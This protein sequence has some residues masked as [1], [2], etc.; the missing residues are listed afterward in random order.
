MTAPA[1]EPRLL[2]LGP[3]RWLGADGAAVDYRAERR[4]QLL[5]WLA[6]HAGRWLER[7]RIAAWLWPDHELGEARRNLRKVL[8]RAREVPGTHALQATETAL[9]WPIATDAQAIETASADE[10]HR[11]WRG[12]PLGGLDDPA[13]STWTDWL[14]QARTELT[15]R[16]QQAA[17]G[18]LRHAG[19]GAAEALARRL[20][21]LDPLDESAAQALVRALLASGQAAA[22]RQTVRAFAGR[23]AEELGVEPSQALTSLVAAGAPAVAAADAQAF[24]GRRLELRSL[25]QQLRASASALLTISGPGGVGKSRLARQLLV[26]VGAAYAGGARLVDLQ[27]VPDGG[28]ALSALALVLQVP[29]GA[30]G[31]RLDQVL[32]ALPQAPSLLVLD[33]TEH[34]HELARLVQQLRDAAPVLALVVTTR[35]RLHLPDEQV[36][37]LAGLEVPDDSSQDAEAAAA[38]DAVRLFEQRARAARPGF[39]LASC[40][41]AVIRIVE[42]VAGLPLA[43]ELAAGWVRLLPPEEIARDLHD[44]IEL[45]QRDPG[46]TSLPFGAESMRVALDRSWDLAAPA[47]RQALA[48]LSVFRGGF[49][50]AAARAVA[51]VALP[52]LASLVDKSLLGVDNDGR[53]AAHP[54][55]AAYARERLAVQAGRAAEVARRHR[56]HFAARLA[57]I[58]RQVHTPGQLQALREFDAESENLRVA[59]HAAIEASATDALQAM[60]LPLAIC[61]ELRGRWVEGVAW[62]QQAVDH[63]AHAVSRLPPAL[64]CAL[65]TLQ[66]RCG[67]TDVAEASARRGHAGARGMRDRA[68]LGASLSILGLVRWQRGDPRAAQR[69]FEAAL[70]HARRSGDLLGIATYAN[71]VCMAL[72]P[73]AAWDEATERCQEALAAARSLGSPK[74]IATALNHLGGIAF[75]QRRLDEAERAWDEGLALMRQMELAPLEVTFHANLGFVHFERRQLDLAERHFNE[76]A[77][78]DPARVE[79]L[80]RVGAF[81]GLGRIA[82]QR[83]DAAAVAHCV[84]RA[85]EISRQAGASTRLLEA[86]IVYGE[87]RQLAG[88]PVEAAACWLAAI[89]TGRLHAAQVVVVQ[90]MLD[91]L[92]LDDA[93]RAEARAQAQ[94]RPADLAVTHIL[95][96]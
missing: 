84:R 23:V 58:A 17:H 31:D 2:L 78:R 36:L 13:D 83:R 39:E 45:L 34:L 7:D 76:I 24:V 87:G 14:R 4:Y 42:A 55:V 43:I 92:G 21:A 90:Q 10:L 73:R 37:V 51:E 29:V 48:A 57:D 54:L 72:M 91:A 50:R 30:A 74:A 71:N 9:C 33:G 8:F 56:L 52:V 5:L 60:A 6:W 53:F 75:V 44:S 65:A 12:E 67:A 20:L 32:R 81:L 25:Q 64:W 61:L 86:L 38:F 26:A 95:A 3:V 88:A 27:D 89:D 62:L 59:W 47:E 28:A 19:A 80:S 22:A 46:A 49:T 18:R 40:L 66:F 93:A 16:W 1:V 79:P 35:S 70:R 85:L 11:L 41:P 69:R 15:A 82:V 63:D 94:A 68:V 77:R 96:G